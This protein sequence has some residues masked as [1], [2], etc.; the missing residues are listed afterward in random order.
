MANVTSSSLTTFVTSTCNQ[1]TTSGCA[2]ATQIPSNG[3]L[4]NPDALAANGSTLYVGNSN[5]TVA[6]YNASTNAYRGVGDAPGL[7][8]AVRACR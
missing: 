6:V 2:S 8:R 5:G 7:E 3:H 4:S 1:T